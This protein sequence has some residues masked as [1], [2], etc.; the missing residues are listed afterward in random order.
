MLA[1]GEEGEFSYA[2]RAYD[3]AELEAM[4][5][6]AGFARVAIHGSL[7]GGR[8]READPVVAVARAPL[9]TRLAR[10]RP[11]SRAGR[12]ASVHEHRP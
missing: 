6:D 9:W 8:W 10:T 3:P 12:T 7:D 1:D 4:L 2:V 11:A 5:R